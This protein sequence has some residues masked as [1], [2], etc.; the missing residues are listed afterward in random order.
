MIAQGAMASRVY[1]DAP[2]APGASLMLSGEA[3]AHL[4]ALRV[5]KGERL[6]VFNGE[7][8]FF[9]RVLRLGKDETEVILE[10][11]KAALP[12]PSLSM[13]LAL[14]IVAQDRMDWAIQKA[15]ELGVRR[16]LPLATQRSQTLP[17]ERVGPRLEHWQK[18][19]IS[20]SRQCGR[21]TL[22]EVL[23]P[24]PFSSW[25]EDGREE[26]IQTKI[27]LHPYGSLPLGRVGAL[28]S[29]SIAVGPEGGF[30]EEEVEAAKA[31]GVQ[32]CALGKALLRTETA[33]AAS[34]AVLLAQAGDL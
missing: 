26:E 16:I 11:Q 20:A 10:Q 1:V 7:K 15:T 27:L 9:A 13:I 8:E 3:L 31:S 25:I 6:T 18:V 4:R 21:A 2:L 28:E 19:A 5:K 24:V 17:Q 32:V 14:A 34:L 33:V 23:P 30:A 22:A 29:V 12:L